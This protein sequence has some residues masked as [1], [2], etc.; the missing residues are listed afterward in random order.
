M[1][2]S[3]IQDLVKLLDVDGLK[4]GFILG[5]EFQANIEADEFD[6]GDKKA[7]VVLDQPITTDYL[8][9]QTGDIGEFYPITLFFSFKS[10]LDWKPLQHETDAVTPANNGIR[11]FISLLQAS[12]DIDEVINEGTGLEF[13]NLLDVNVSGKSL[14]LRIKLHINKSVCVAKPA[15]FCKP[16]TLFTNG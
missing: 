5:D 6:F 3:I 4:Y 12:P 14:Q 13:H 1:I 15:P 2:V 10:E 8:I 7:L 9:T 16:A 11:Q